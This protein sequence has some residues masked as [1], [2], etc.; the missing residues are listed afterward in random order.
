MKTLNEFLLGSNY[1]TQE[2][3]EKYSGI[4]EGIEA[5]IYNEFAPTIQNWVIEEFAPEIENWLIDEY[6]P[7]LEKWLKNTFIKKFKIN[8]KEKS[9]HDFLNDEKE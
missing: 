4:L 6:S 3:L 8:K 1:V 5:W 7:T 2:E 9:L